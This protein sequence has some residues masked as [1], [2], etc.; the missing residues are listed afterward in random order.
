MSVD[1]SLLV[2]VVPRM[3]RTMCLWFVLKKRGVEPE[4]AHNSKV[5]DTESCCFCFSCT[6]FGKRFLLNSERDSIL[7][8]VVV[9]LLFF[10][11]VVALSSGRQSY[12]QT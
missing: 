3:P 12:S 10:V 4:D 11:D 2:V 8:M 1:G 5:I 7:L 6:V 9:L